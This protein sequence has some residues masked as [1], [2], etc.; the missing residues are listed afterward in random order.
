MGSDMSETPSY[1]GLLNTLA[2]G[3]SEAEC[4]F[5]AWADVTT[6]EDL[7]QVLTTVAI[8]EGEHGKAFVKRLCELGVPF[9]P[10]DGGDLAN[11]M[12]IASSTTLTD[13]EKFE[14]LDLTG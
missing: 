12:S 2:V 4:W 6:N 13:G 11:R 10:S 3:E 8:R 5:R 9:E 1:V 7:R 14:K